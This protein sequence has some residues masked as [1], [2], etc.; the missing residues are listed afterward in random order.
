MTM[1][2]TEDLLA[3]AG[4]R[5]RVAVPAQLLPSAPAAARAPDRAGSA[6]PPAEPREVVLRP[7][8]LADVHRGQ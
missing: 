4:A 6:A 1:L 7:L 5:H 8:V 3:G 2:T